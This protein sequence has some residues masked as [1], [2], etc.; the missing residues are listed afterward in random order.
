MYNNYFLFYTNSDECVIDSLA[1]MFNLKIEE[2]E[3]F[4]LIPFAILP[5]LKNNLLSTLMS[6]TY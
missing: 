4:K 2:V 1:K 3:S 5:F 6:M